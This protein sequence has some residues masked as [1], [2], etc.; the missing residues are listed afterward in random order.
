M[1]D[2]L[3]LAVLGLWLMACTPA[4]TATGT[5]PDESGVFALTVPPRTAQADANALALVLVLD[6]ASF[7]ELDGI[8][9]LSDPDG[10]SLGRIEPFG[11]QARTAGG[12][13]RLPMAPETAPGTQVR[14]RL[15][16]TG[17][18]PTDKVHTVVFNA[19]LWFEWQ[20]AQ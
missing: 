4:V 20:L 8:E 19:R 3:M 7:G 13:Y 6:I 17:D 15:Q 10:R 9:V 2:R 18:T 1:I 12:R 11:A 14:L 16:H 5:G